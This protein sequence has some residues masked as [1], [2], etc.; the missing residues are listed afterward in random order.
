VNGVNIGQLF[1]KSEEKVK[2]VGVEE[3]GI[4]RGVS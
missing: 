3:E 2:S 4:R 1:G